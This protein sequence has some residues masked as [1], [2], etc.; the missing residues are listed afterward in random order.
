MG[1]RLLKR[2]FWDLICVSQAINEQYLTILV[3]IITDD[4]TNNWLL[5]S[6]IG[7]RGTPDEKVWFELKLVKLCALCSLHLVVD[8]ERIVVR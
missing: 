8:L 2:R 7:E 3:V 4:K 5:V 1:L 6:T